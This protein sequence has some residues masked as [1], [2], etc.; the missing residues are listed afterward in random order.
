MAYAVVSKAGRFSRS[1]TNQVAANLIKIRPA[2]PQELQ[3]QTALRPYHR[4]LQTV[5]PEVQGL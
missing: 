3:L 2:I 5:N 1:F 4:F